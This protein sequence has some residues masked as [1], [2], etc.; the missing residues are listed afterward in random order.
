[1]TPPFTLDQA[2][3]RAWSPRDDWHVRLTH[4]CALHVAWHLDEVLAVVAAADRAGREGRYAAVALAYDAAPAFDSALVTAAPVEAPADTPVDAQCSRFPLAVVAEFDTA[5]AEVPPPTSPAPPAAVREHPTPGTFLPAIDADTFARRVETVRERIRLGDTYQVNLTFPVYGPVPDDLH[6]W[7]DALCH[8]QQAGY[9]AHLVCGP[10][11]VLSLSPELFFER[12]RDTLVVRPM[13]GTCR[14]GRWLEEDHTLSDTLAT[15]AKARAENVMIVDLLRNDLGRVAR[16]GSVRVTEL[17]SRE[18]YPTLWQLTSTVEAT[19][20]PETTLVEVLRALFPCGSVTGAPKISTM[21]II[22][23][24]EGEPRGLYTGA[25]GLV[26]PGGD[27]TFSVAIRTLL[28]DASEGHGLI[29][30]GAGLTIDSDAT[31]EY[32][33]SL[34]KARFLTAAATR[35]GTF[36][37]L[38]TLRLEDGVLVRLDGHLTRMRTSAAFFGFGWDEEAVREALARAAATHPTGTWRV[39]VLVDAGGGPAVTCT[40]YAEHQGV[41][42][43]AFASAPV[44]GADPFLC[45]KTTARAPYEAA[46]RSRPD[47]DDVV[48]WNAQGEVTESTIANLV[49][50]LDGEKYTPPRTCGLLAGVLRDELVRSGEVR[51]RVLTRGAVARASRVWLVNSLRGW[52]DA[53][54]VR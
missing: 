8:S 12:R 40:E 20:S 50:E 1:M 18:A 28:A 26:R 16:T 43:V 44:D 13:K 27:Y 37:L 6:A 33:E 31:L 5:H 42:R 36:E 54:L 24:L 41:W 9:A 2:V 49:V 25:I 11:H 35:P 15:S 39:R 21:R 7:F 19:V 14:R 48:L 45:N 17:F 23:E 46:R 53:T 22:A 4:P 52:M 34:L 3:F 29:G 38:E 47:V 51:E 32:D 10:L 30:V